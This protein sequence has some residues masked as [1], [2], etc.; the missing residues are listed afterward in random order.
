M[1]LQFPNYSYLSKHIVLGLPNEQR[2]TFIL[3]CLR[4]LDLKYIARTSTDGHGNYVYARDIL[5]HNSNQ[6]KYVGDFVILEKNIEI[7]EQLRK[8]VKT[9]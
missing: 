6:Y 7:P 2:S 3:S 4:H 1:L 5:N 8:F 9:N